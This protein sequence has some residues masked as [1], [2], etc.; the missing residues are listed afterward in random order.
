MYLVKGGNVS[1][2]WIEE[3]HSSSD[4]RVVRAQSRDMRIS[5]NHKII[6]QKSTNEN[7]I[8]RVTH[9]WNVAS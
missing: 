8:V 9:A 4:T 5:I 2:K 7:F 3:L 6:T 1:K